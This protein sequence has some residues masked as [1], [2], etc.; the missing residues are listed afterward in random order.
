[1]CHIIKSLA[2]KHKKMI[3]RTFFER[4]LVV[5]ILI[6]FIAIGFIGG[7]F[8][9]LGLLSN[10]SEK[11]KCVNIPSKD[12]INSYCKLSGYEYGWL[13]SESCGAN[14]IMC[15]KGFLNMKQFDCIKWE[16]KNE[17]TKNN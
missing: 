9:G 5:I 4:H 15:Y 1:M 12:Q 2:Q 11:L 8:F 17:T 7:T 14:E 10:S 16:I 13:S 3:L 6:S